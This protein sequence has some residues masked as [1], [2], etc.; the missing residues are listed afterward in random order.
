[1]GSDAQILHF[2]E[3]TAN[4]TSMSNLLRVNF[5]AQIF[6]AQTYGGIS[7]Y[8]ASL[9]RALAQLPDCS[10]HILAPWHRNAYLAA[11]PPGMVRG[12]GHA[13]PRLPGS[14]QR[15]GGL[16]GSALLHATSRAN[17]LHRTYY[18]PF[19][20]LPTSAVQ[21]LT[22]HDMIHE[23]FPQHFAANDPIAGWK[24]KAVARAE[25]IICVSQNTRAD[26][27]EVY[28]D[29][30]RGKVW[31]THLGFDAMADQSTAESAE[32]FRR[33]VLG[34]D[35]PYLLYVG[36]RRGY[37]NFGGLLQAFSRSALLRAS[38][39][40]LCFGGGA[41]T[42]Q[43][44]QQITQAGVS[45]QVVQLPGDDTILGRCYRH[46]AVL[47]YP[48]LYE[49]FGIPPLEAMSLDC[50]VACSLSSS[51]PEVVGN[52]GA[53]FDPT[54]IEDMQ[55]TLEGLLVSPS[56]REKLIHLGRARTAAFS[57]RQC[58]QQTAAIYRESL[59]T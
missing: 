3:C 44:Q 17:I 45:A 52:A 43:E 55:T 13:P 58:A 14:L 12:L 54:R 26:L 18:Y 38:F 32:Q 1:M 49:G 30:I 28:G 7:R 36:S 10:P 56:W 50:P 59:L 6:G 24:R 20:Q 15:A 23:R 4:A 34:D 21:V 31:V 40:L 22:V 48:S 5:D 42:A 2:Q 57:W 35:V 27:L 41:F 47:V 33:R 37:K 8:I 25:H 46:A 11:M 16:L 53:Y 29:V 19:F 51:I 9:A 39:K